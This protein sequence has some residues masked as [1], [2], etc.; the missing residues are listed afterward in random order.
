MFKKG[1]FPY[2]N[3]L[4]LLLL[5]SA[6]SKHSTP[7]EPSASTPP[8]TPLLTQQ[9]DP[10]PKD[11]PEVEKPKYYVNTKNFTIHP[12]DQTSEKKIALLTFDDGPK[13]EVTGEILD[14]LDRYQ[15]KSIW[16]IS[17][18]N[19]GWD[20]QPSS[21]KADPFKAW[22][23]KIHDRGHIIANHTWT[24][25]NLRKI[26][27]EKQKQEILSMNELLTSITGEKVRYFRPPFGADTEFQRK[28][29]KDEGMQ[30]MNWSVGSLDW[31]H[32]DPE[33][34]INQV[35]STIHNGGNILMH[36]LPVEAKALDS[37][38]KKLTDLGYTFV[39]PTEVITD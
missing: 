30:T 4:L 28:L 10:A 25:E 39:L 24:H 22:V 8:A 14:I 19:Y 9:Q 13:G 38:L 32:K 5:M 33:K 16:F 3:L 1:S 15:A 35:V 11:N 36:D 26:S 27:P 18:F 17:G 29:M 23:K 20:Y 12:V 6:C 37:I 21:T 34:V 31:E 7:T 2:L